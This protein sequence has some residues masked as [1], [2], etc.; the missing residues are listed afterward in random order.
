M[1]QPRT[2]TLA[3]AGF[4]RISGLSLLGVPFAPSTIWAMVKRKEFP[5]PLQ[6]RPG[7][8]AWRISDVQEWLREQERSALARQKSAD[9]RRGQAL[10]E[11]RRRRQS[12]NGAEG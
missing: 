6:L 2:P 12:A 3:H 5:A 8:T 11:A 1:Q 10:T 9:A 7:V 4:T